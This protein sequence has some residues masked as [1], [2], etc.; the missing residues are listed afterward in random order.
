MI[1]YVTLTMKWSTIRSA[2]RREE[3]ASVYGGE[4]SISLATC[5]LTFAQPNV[6]TAKGPG[7]LVQ[8]YLACSSQNHQLRSFRTVCCLL[9][10]VEA[11]SCFYLFL[12]SHIIFQSVWT[13]WEA[14]FLRALQI[15][16][17]KVCAGKHPSF[18]TRTGVF[19]FVR[20]VHSNLRVVFR[21]VWIVKESPT[22]SS[23]VVYV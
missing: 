18:S 17:D 16:P 19:S 8:G 22:R 14:A 20:L 7:A 15:H 9:V 12:H 4:S 13:F 10:T 23:I 6:C 3:A 11:G 21:R 5:S 1:F 2:W